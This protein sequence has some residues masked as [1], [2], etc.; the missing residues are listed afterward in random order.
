MQVESQERIQVLDGDAILFQ[1]PRVSHSRELSSEV[2]IRKTVN[3]QYGIRL[4]GSSIENRSDQPFVEIHNIYGDIIFNGYL[5]SSVRVVSLYMPVSEN[6]SWKRHNMTAAIPNLS[7]GICSMAIPTSLNLSSYE[8]SVYRSLKLV[9]LSVTTLGATNCVI[10]PSLPKG[11]TLSATPCIVSGFAEEVLPRTVFTITCIGLFNSSASFSLTVIE[12]FD[13]VVEVVR[14]YSLNAAY[15]TYKIIDLDTNMTVV[16][17]PPNSGQQDN[18]EVA[19]RFC[20]TASHYRINMGSLHSSW[21]QGSFVSVLVLIGNQWEQVLHGHY[22]KQYLQLPSSYVFTVRPFIR[23]DSRWHYKM[24]VV[25]SDWMSR[26]TVGWN[27][28]RSSLMPKSSNQIQLYKR[29]WIV[30]SLPKSGGFSLGIRYRYGCLVF[31][32]GHEVFRNNLPEG[33]VTEKMVAEGE[34]GDVRYRFVTLPFRTVRTPTMDPQSYLKEGENVIAIALIGLLVGNLTS[35]VF[36]A[37]VFPFDRQVSRLM[38]VTFRSEGMDGGIR[39]LWDW[40]PLTDVHSDACGPNWIE[41]QFNND[42]REWINSVALQRSFTHPNT[43]WH[44]FKVLARNR[45]LEPWTELVNETQ[46]K[47]WTSSPEKVVFLQ[48]NRPYNVYRFANFSSDVSECRWDLNHIDL[49]AD[50]ISSPIPDLSYESP[51]TAFLNVEMAEV[52]PSHRLYTHY[53]VDPPLPPGLEL[54]P[55]TGVLT[56][57]PLQ[58]VTNCS[59]TITAVKLTGEETFFPIVISVVRC[60]HEYNL[61]TATMYVSSFPADLNWVVYRGRGQDRSVI[62]RSTFFGTY[63]SV[64]YVDL[65]L[66]PGIYVFGLKRMESSQ[67]P[68]C[69]YSLSIDIGSVRFDIAQLD[70]DGSPSFRAFSSLLPFQ[71]NDSEWTATTNTSLVSDLWTDVAFDDS[72]WF[73][74]KAAN[75]NVTELG[76]LY[77]RKTFTI[78]NLDDYQVLNV[79]AFFLDGLAVYFNGKLVALFN[80]PSP[81][82]SATPALSSHDSRTPVF[83]HILLHHDGAIS[84]RNVI[85]F[86]LHRSRSRFSA[87]P[88]SFDASGV[89]GVEECSPVLDSTTHMTTSPDIEA[90]ASNALELSLSTMVQFPREESSFIQ[91]MVENQLG[92]RFNQFAFQNVKP[93]HSLSYSFSGSFDDVDDTMRMV[94]KKETTAVVGRVEASAPAGLFGFRGLRFDQQNSDPS[95]LLSVL[96]FLTLYCKSSEAMCPGI[97]P[98]PSVE[99]GQ[100]SVSPCP[101]GYSGY[102]YRNCTNGVLSDIKSELCVL[103]EPQDLMYGEKSFS[104]VMN[105]RSSSGEPSY[106]FII[107]EFSFKGH[108]LPEG[109]TMNPRTG[110]IAGIPTQLQDVE[111]YTIVGSNEKGST[112]TVISIMV[113]LGQCL[114]YG[115]YSQ[116]LV[117]NTEKCDC[118]QL[119][120]FV[121]TK[122][123]RCELGDMDGVWGRE[124]GFCI[125]IIVLVFIVAICIMVVFIIIIILVKINKRKLIYEKKTVVRKF[126]KWSVC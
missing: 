14:F 107:Q 49:F 90:T 6:A 19:V 75:L 67:T 12:C 60:S 74:G 125:P 23:E 53:R 97:D 56:G 122:S 77:I 84:G 45:Q 95:S 111:S 114:A 99:E 83:F 102:C 11:L 85:A 72:Q 33:N 54:D 96:S 113:R 36:D 30:D 7:S 63:T 78:P 24:G 26:S 59:F 108:P 110:E 43:P 112:A 86:E 91:W 123:R 9:S 117:G 124:R 105:T 50:S 28:E 5:S 10:S 57:T 118:R 69:G 100:I 47:W 93:V 27:E 116:T 101:Y 41:I 51:L 13:S 73:V 20:G 98:F 29:I 104:F 81:F 89:F 106:K 52:Y 66:E 68:L 126:T 25:S 1:T 18:S 17:V 38:D 87:V 121:G 109:L 103:R 76:P 70:S 115:P 16:E 64:V 55:P 31:L 88:F 82:D 44:S 120:N 94:E 8:V 80:M 2:C 119:G 40:D 39:S 4:I 79:R 58:L 61:I 37:V 21:N 15:E 22:D 48:N 35:S 32:N 65:C 92:S 62:K 34:Y 71:I 46:L 3:E 42:R